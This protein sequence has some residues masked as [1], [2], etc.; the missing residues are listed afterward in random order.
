VLSQLSY[1]PTA[2]TA[3][4]LKHLLRFQNPFLRIFMTWS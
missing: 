3:L 4:I 2:R 1:T